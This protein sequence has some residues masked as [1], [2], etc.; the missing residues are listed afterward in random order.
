MEDGPDE[1]QTRTEA[2]GGLGGGVEHFGEGR[3]EELASDDVESRRVWNDRGP[4]TTHGHSPTAPEAV[5]QEGTLSPCQLM[6]TMVCYTCKTVLACGGWQEALGPK[7][8]R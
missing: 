5:K 3:E 2:A 4:M 6:E 7:G 8:T 1:V